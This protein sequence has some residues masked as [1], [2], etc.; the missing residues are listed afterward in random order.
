MD[1]VNKLEKRKIITIEMLKIFGGSLYFLFLGWYFVGLNLLMLAMGSFFIYFGGMANLYVMDF[2]NFAMP[3]AIKSKKE[4]NEI[5]KKH[6][7]RK[8]CMLKSDSKLKILADRFFIFN[9]WCSLG[10]FVLLFGSF[11]ILFGLCS[12]LYN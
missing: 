7:N 6:S 3:V 11:L 12:Y 5:E 10:D 2:N 8:I 1:F 4:F 9:K